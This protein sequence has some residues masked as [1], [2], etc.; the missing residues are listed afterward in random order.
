M[1]VILLIILICASVTLC[2]LIY[3][4]FTI[5]ERLTFAKEH[6]QNE[7][8]EYGIKEKEIEKYT[9]FMDC[10]ESEKS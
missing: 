3:L 1:K 2:L 10:V 7:M 6:I 9:K 5:Y 8:R 4:I